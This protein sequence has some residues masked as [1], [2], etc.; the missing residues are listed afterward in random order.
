MNTLATVG[1]KHLKDILLNNKINDVT[2][3]N[4]EE[5]L[6]KLKFIG[7]IEKDEKLNIRYM[8]KHPNN[9]QTAVTRSLLYPDNRSNALKFV[10]DVISRSFE[11][12][13]KYLRRQ[14]IPACR[15]VIA[16][17]IRSQQGLQN[18][19]YTYSDDT[20]FCCDIDVLIERVSS[21]LSSIQE[22]HT[23]LFESLDEKEK[24]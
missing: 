22:E 9:W 19:K 21:R 6:S 5:I 2:M 14:N 23:K 8:T 4:N 13:D 18:L 20:K 17:L 15:A 16:D 10:R 11:I 7:F 24:V 1:L 3:D 12:I